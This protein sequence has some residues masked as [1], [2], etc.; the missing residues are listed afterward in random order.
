[1]SEDLLNA[2]WVEKYRP[3]SLEDIVLEQEQK[4]FFRKCLKTGDIPHLL[5]LGPPGSG[6]TTT[7]RVIV[8]SIVKHEMDVMILNGSDTTGVDTMRTEI[9]GFL[10]SPPYVSKLKIIFIDEFDYMSIQA[11]AA[12]R[13]MLEKYSDNGRFICTANYKSKI[14]DPLHSRFQMFEMKT[15]KEDYAI[16][17]VTDILKKEEVEFDVDSVKTIVKNYIP[18]LRK[19]LNTIQRNVVDKKLK[20]IDVNTIITNEKKICSLVVSMCDNLD[21]D[22]FTKNKVINQNMP[23]LIKLVMKEEPDYRGIY[24]TLFDHEGLPLWGKI[25]V[26]QYS[27]QHQGAAVPSAHFIACINTIILAGM[28]FY[29]TFNITKPK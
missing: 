28:N 18:D 15:I 26:N 5:F 6:K 25:V 27:N 2:L 29:R 16:N 9:Q 24:Q 10:K 14:I 4:D 12:M 19:A 3:R 1:M 8:E 17:Y 7:A 11:Q 22:E 23:E 21:K 20:K 13:N